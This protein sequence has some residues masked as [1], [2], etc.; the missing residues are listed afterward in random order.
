MEVGLFSRYYIVVLKVVHNEI[1]YNKKKTISFEHEVAFQKCQLCI[2][3]YKKCTRR[4]E[5]T[6]GQLH[7][8]IDD[9]CKVN[10]VA[11][12]C[13]NLFTILHFSLFSLCLF[14]FIM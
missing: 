2:I 14:Y 9:L 10:I 5:K 3:H 7:N 1:G 11:P 4:V 6:H 13:V 12:Y 8:K